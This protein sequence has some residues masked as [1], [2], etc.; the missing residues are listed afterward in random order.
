MIEVM[1]APAITLQDIFLSELKLP[2]NNRKDELDLLGINRTF[3]DF[4][5][6]QFVEFKNIWSM[7]GNGT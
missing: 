5:K 1:V 3:Y 2:E 6:T 7:F 4:R